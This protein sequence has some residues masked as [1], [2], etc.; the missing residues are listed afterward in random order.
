[1]Q[2]LMGTPIPIPNTQWSA[3]MTKMKNEQ[4]RPASFLPEHRQARVR[5]STIRRS[6]IQR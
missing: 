3:N 4:A 5:R 2:L 6:T 1:M